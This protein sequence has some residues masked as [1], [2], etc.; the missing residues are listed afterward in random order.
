MAELKNA[1]CSACRK[2]EASSI[3]VT[4]AN[5]EN[6]FRLCLECGMEILRA[7]CK[8]SGVPFTEK[9]EK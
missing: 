8:E 4:L 6:P 2:Q 9:D 3:K 1:M 7:L 5:S